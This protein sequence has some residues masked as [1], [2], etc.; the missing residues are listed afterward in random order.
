MIT[1]TFTYVGLVFYSIVIGIG[2]FFIGYFVGRKYYYAHRIYASQKH[3]PKK[4]VKRKPT[5]RWRW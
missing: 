5:K 1:F 2:C 4:V 3:K